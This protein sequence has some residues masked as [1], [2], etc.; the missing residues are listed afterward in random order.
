MDI[1]KLA[2]LGSQVCLD[3]LLLYLVCRYLPDKDTKMMTEIS[4]MSNSI[5]RLVTL[6]TAEMRPD[7]GQGRLR[8]S[9]KVK[10][11][12]DDDALGAN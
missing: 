3:G 6:W 5:D 9:D 4:G 11:G 8:L 1:F 2:E 12:K 7:N 10:G